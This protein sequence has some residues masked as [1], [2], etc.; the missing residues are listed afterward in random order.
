M[1]LID[2]AQTH[3]SK[4]KKEAN[5]DTFRRIQKSGTPEYHRSTISHFS[6]IKKFGQKIYKQGD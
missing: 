2:R 4:L 1:G 3:K 6:V 5:D